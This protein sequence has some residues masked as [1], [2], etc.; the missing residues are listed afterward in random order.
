MRTQLQ[1]ALISAYRKP[2]EAEIVLDQII[3]LDKWMAKMAEIL[4]QIANSLEVR[5]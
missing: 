5:E 2:Q 3:L 4:Q 1:D